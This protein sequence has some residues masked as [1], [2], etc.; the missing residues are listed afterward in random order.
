M[1]FCSTIFITTKKNK[2]KMKAINERQSVDMLPQDFKRYKELKEIY[3]CSH[4]KMFSFLLSL[5]HSRVESGK[6]IVERKLKQLLIFGKEEITVHRLRIMCYE[7]GKTV[8]H[9]TVMEVCNLY[10]EEIN[11]FNSNLNLGHV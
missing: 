10:A 4:A 7:K 8:G 6:A 5:E 9:K 11:L 1:Y 2:K 3:S